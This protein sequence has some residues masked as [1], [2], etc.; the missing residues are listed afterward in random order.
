MARQGA[1]D[2]PAF[3]FCYHQVWRGSRSKPRDEARGQGSAASPLEVAGPRGAR[4][5]E[6]V[7]IAKE[8]RIAWHRIRAEYIAGVSQRALAEKYKV[9]RSAIERHSRLER[10]TEQREIAKVKIQEKVVQKTAEL[11]ADNAT[12]AAGIKRKGLLMLE[13][14]FD[15]FAQITATEHRESENGVTDIKRLRDLTAAYKD[16]TEDMPK[17]DAPNDLLQALLDL[18]RGASR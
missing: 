7:T 17:A 5:E 10:W 9:P 8:K 1:T 3:C 16:L 4:S 18:E 14:L 13:R 12:I 2:T 6:R 15:D 11:T